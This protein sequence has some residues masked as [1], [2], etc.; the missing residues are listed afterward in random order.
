MLVRS[1]AAHNREFLYLLVWLQYWRSVG[2]PVAVV[3]ICFTDFVSLTGPEAGVGASVSTTDRNM[4]TCVWKH[5]SEKSFH[6]ICVHKCVL[7]CS[8]KKML[9]HFSSVITT[10]EQ[11]DSGE[12]SDDR[13]D[14]GAVPQYTRR[15]ITTAKV[16]P[17]RER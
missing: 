7:S 3:Y 10:P 2:S 13:H 14:K 5:A 12:I 17:R 8:Q 6:S 1:L 15:N 4:S 9:L 11:R 16:L